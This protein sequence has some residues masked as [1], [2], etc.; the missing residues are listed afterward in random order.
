MTGLL[1]SSSMLQGQHQPRNPKRDPICRKCEGRYAELI[2]TL[3]KFRAE[4]PHG[5]LKE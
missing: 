1:T 3:P 4:V 2:N 5:S